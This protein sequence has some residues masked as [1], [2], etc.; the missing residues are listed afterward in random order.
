MTIILPK[1]PEP[2]MVPA[3]TP[4]MPPGAEEAKLFSE[5]GVVMLTDK[6]DQDNIMPLVKQIMTYNMLPEAKQPEEIKLVI[7]S[8]GGSVFSAWHLIDV[9]KQ[10]RIPVSTIAMGLAASC[11]VLTLMSGVK[12]KRY[13]TQ[14][15]SIMSHQYAWGSAGKEH[16]LYAKVK[17]F[18]MASNRMVEHYKKCTGKSVSY[19]RKN[20]LGPTDE[21]MTPAEA[22]KHGI[23]DEVIT[24]Y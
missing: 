15:T 10:S 24:T 7:N 22:V 3:P 18:E 17:E 12:G 6:F 2:Q 20:L 19:I 9:I 1:G 5:S 4:P 23:I 16:E 13:A 8:P 14:N 21:W 11:G